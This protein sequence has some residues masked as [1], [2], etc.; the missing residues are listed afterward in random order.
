MS[1][2]ISLLVALGIGGLIGGWVDYLLS[3][4]REIEQHQRE[5]KEN[6]YKIFLE[7]LIGFF[8]GWE[9]KSERKRNFMEELYTHAPLYASSGVIRLANK[10]VESFADKKLTSQA[11]DKLANDLVLAIRNEMGVDKNDSLD[12]SDIKRYKLD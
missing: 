3:R 4:K 2:L 8:D 6:Q 11:R 12:S 7:N 1:N 9:G 10:Y 5:R